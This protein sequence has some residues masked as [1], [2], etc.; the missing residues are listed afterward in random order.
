MSAYSRVEVNNMLSEI[1]KPGGILAF[2]FGTW[3]MAFVVGFL[4]MSVVLAQAAE[5][6][7]PVPQKVPAPQPLTAIPVA[8]VATQAPEV[9]NL[10]RTFNTLL[11]PSPRI[12]MIEGKLPDIIEEIELEFWRTKRVLQ[13]QPTLAEL[14]TWQQLWEKRQLEMTHWLTLLTTRATQLE[15]A[16]SQL[17]DLEKLWSQTRNAANASKA[18]GPILQEIS[19]TIA[20]VQTVQAPMQTKHKAMLDLQ[21]RV[22]NEVELCG[23]ALA[24]IGQ[25]QQKAV[26]GLLKRETLPIWSTYLWRQGRVEGPSRMLEIA[27]GQWADIERYIH[28]PSKG[29]P[30]HVGVFVLVTIFFYMMRRH[31]RQW[32]AADKDSFLAVTVFDRPFSA[33]LVATLFFATSPSFSLSTPSTVRRLFNI[34]ELPP[35]IR[36]TKP[37]A[38]PIVVTGLYTVA[39]LFTLNTIREAFAGVLLIEQ[40]VLLAEVFLGIV[41]LARGFT[42]G[43]LRRSHGQE[44]SLEKL[45]GLRLLAGLVLL[46]FAIS[47]VAGAL[48]YM[49]LARLLASSV[50]G[51]GVLALALFAYVRVIGGVVAFALRV[52]PFRLLQMVQHH[53]ELL[54]RRIYRVLI[55]LA[56]VAWLARVLDYVG[57]LGPVFSIGKT[58]LAVKLERGSISISVEDVFAFFL[59][60]WIAYL[61][62]ALIRFILQED[63]YPRI[64]VARGLSYAIS[65]LLN[66]VIIAL[67]FVIALGVVGVNL[68]K[69]TVL[70]GAF[71]VG[72]GFGLQSIVNNFVSGLILLFERPIHVGDTVQV[73][74]LLGEVRR[75]GIR[76]SIV[77][78]W[79]GSDIIVPNS[80][81]V[82]E[83]VTN[84]TLSDQLRRIDLPVGVNYGADPKKVIEVMEAVAKAHPDVLKYPPPQGFFVGYGDSSI[85]FE[86][87]AWTGQFGKWFKIRSDLAVALFDAVH[88]AEGMTFPFP[89]REVR[90]LRDPE[91]KSGVVPTPGISQTSLPGGRQEPVSEKNKTGRTGGDE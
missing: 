18:P 52:W 1:K 23:K 25:A 4:F 49:R 44:K 8:E 62:S 19:A 48:G 77:H 87:R 74:D 78:T 41:V 69:V 51:G 75:I 42:L 10:L 80:Q 22:A 33:A 79:Q 39:A 61:L 89:Q 13:Q 54:E 2:L 67:G 47:L 3:A 45:S 11:A 65:S 36:L 9:S 40:V 43:G 27:A 66:Y 16:L 83:Q 60:V 12:E 35:M 57:F 76:S 59:T 32:S 53:C 81:M 17:A 34:L 90:V 30:L 5:Q 31:V 15:E 82:T 88:A 63:V 70:A 14:Q 29:M 24:D 68:S 20:A 55:W 26:G 64:R 73:G 86:L 84:W 56:V 46:I 58:I 6:K 85:N 37:V 71:G 28:D 50:L 7:R 91:E 21:S 72:I 38:S